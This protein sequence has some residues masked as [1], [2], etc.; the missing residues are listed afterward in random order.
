MMQPSV[1]ATNG[2]ARKREL[3]N[4]QRLTSQHRNAFIIP[5]S[6]RRYFPRCCDR[7]RTGRRLKPLGAW[8]A[9][10]LPSATVR[11]PQTHSCL[12]SLPSYVGRRGTMRFA[13]VT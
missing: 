9:I 3:I 5:I 7:T 11:R 2:N 8:H 6:R 13:M 12:L 4:R 1:S 10:A